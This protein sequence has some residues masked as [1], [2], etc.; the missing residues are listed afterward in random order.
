[1][2]FCNVRHFVSEVPKKA[3]SLEVGFPETGFQPIQR[4]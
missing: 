4:E 2:D 3:K 1:M